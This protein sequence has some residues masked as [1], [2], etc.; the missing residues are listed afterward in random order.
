MTPEAPSTEQLDAL[1]T[2][3]RQALWRDGDLAWKLDPM[4]FKLYEQIRSCPGGVFAT[5]GARKL[6]KSYVH[7]VIVLETAI[8]NPGK[9]IN[10]AAITGKESRGTLL[11]ILEEISADAPDDCKGRHGQQEN[12]WLMPNGAVV[13]LFG[14]ETKQD[15]EQRAFHRVAERLKTFFPRLPMLLL[16]DGLYANGPVMAACRTN[17][18]QFMIVLQDGSLKSVGE[19]FKGLSKLTTG[20]RCEMIWGGRRQRFTWINHIEYRY[21][22]GE[23]KR[24]VV[25]VVVCDESWQEWDE[26]VGALS[27]PLRADVGIPFRSGPDPRHRSRRGGRG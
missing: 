12:Q 11:P 27:S 10:W 18:W 25:H 5:E 20:N 24:Q 14:A 26:K 7:G 21:D 16:L 17:H 15:C 19:E 2:E 3:E 6:G 4:Q 13:Q 1:I 22:K 9:R 23:K 8:R